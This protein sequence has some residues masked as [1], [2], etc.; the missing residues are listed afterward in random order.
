MGV[1]WAATHAVTRRRVALK[2]LKDRDADASHRRAFVREARAACAVSHDGILPVHDVIESDDGEPA[3]VMDLLKGEPLSARLAREGKLGLEETADILLPVFAAVGAAHAAGVVHRDL[4]PDNIFLSEAGVRILDFGLAKAT[5]ID[6]GMARSIGNRSGEIVGTPRYMSPEQAFAEQDVDYRA[7]IWSLG[8]VLYQ[9][10]SGT[11]PTASESLG[12]ILKVILSGAITPLGSIAPELSPELAATVD[13][14]LSRDRERRPSGLSE[15]ARVLAQAAGRPVPEIAPPRRR[16]E[17]PKP[18]ESEPTRSDRESV[19]QA[20]ES[21]SGER[22]RPRRSLVAWGMAAIF[23][24]AVM[25]FALSSD[26]QRRNDVVAGAAPPIASEPEDVSS[27]ATAPPSA[28]LPPIVASPVASEPAVD[29]TSS[30][31][32]QPSGSARPKRRKPKAAASGIYEDPS[33]LDF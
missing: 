7:D 27:T 22:S 17:A 19:Q 18:P 6:A 21:D 31:S 24:V 13:R 15:V 20:F 10:M 3:L 29:P 4:K 14:M 2:F 32:A 16:G 1:V 25:A 11:L 28:A 9:C 26:P 12:Q 33:D 8:M 5:L 30:A 23:L